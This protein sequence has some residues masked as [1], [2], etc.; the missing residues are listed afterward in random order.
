M[1]DADNSS[2]ALK[3]VP[4]SGAELGF[5]VRMAGG[6]ADGACQAALLGVA[7]LTPGINNGF[8]P[9]HM[10]TCVHTQDNL[11]L[12]EEMSCASVATSMV[13]AAPDLPAPASCTHCGTLSQA[14]PE[15]ISG[16]VEIHSQI[17]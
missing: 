7:E 12:A 4:C 11:M 10:H 16:R 2:P 3:D 13:P 5:T 8:P 14:G 6:E 17:F 9:V 15:D 1:P